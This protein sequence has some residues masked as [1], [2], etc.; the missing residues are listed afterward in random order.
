M[1]TYEDAELSEAPPIGIVPE[2][3]WISDR[4]TELTE[5]CNRY[6]KANKPIPDAWKWEMLRHGRVLRGEP[7]VAEWMAFLDPHARTISADTIGVVFDQVIE[8]QS[9]SVL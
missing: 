9:G 7:S 3:I 4:F 8:R 2:K 6:M 5:A 1:S